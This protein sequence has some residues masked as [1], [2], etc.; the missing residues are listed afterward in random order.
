MNEAAAN[1]KI[2]K[3]LSYAAVMVN[4]WI[5]VKKRTQYLNYFYSL[6]IDE[7]NDE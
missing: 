3:I 5:P 1:R 4:L 7:E 2:K 6:I